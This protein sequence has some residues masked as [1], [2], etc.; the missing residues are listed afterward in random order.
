MGT[1]GGGARRDA[2][3]RVH[4]SAA[5]A[6]RIAVAA[7][8]LAGPRPGGTPHLGHARRVV[9]RLGVVQIDAVNVLVRAHRM[10]LYS[11][12][13][14]HPRDLLDRLVAGGHLVETWAH[15]ASLVPAAHYPLLWWRRRRPHPWRTLTALARD[16]PDLL[17]AVHAAVAERGPLTAGEL[18]RAGR[19]S[20]WWGWGPA[21]QALEVLLWQG[22]VAVRR[23][24]D[25][26][27]EYGLP[28]RLLPAAALAPPPPD[29]EARRELVRVAARAL[30]VATLADL[31]DHHR[32]STRDLAPVVA[33]MAEEGTLL[34]VRVEGWREDAYLD[35][36]ARI[37]RRTGA[38]ALVS[39][40]DPVMWG[41]ARA[42]RL[43][44]FRY[45]LEI[46]TPAHRRVHG[47]YVLPFLLGD[48]PVARVD[49]RADRRGGSLQVR[50]AHA[51]DAAPPGAA[52][53][54]AAELRTLARWLG[55]HRV[56]T[57]DRGDLAPALRAA[58]E[59]VGTDGPG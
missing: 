22:R 41:R 37:P 49:L 53:R 33:G 38:A 9:D 3:S 18:E 32:Q 11:R 23:R 28:E 25:F 20:P 48:R 34:P 44:G 15:E 39:P 43:W 47:Y 35:P 46:Y 21:K 40:F 26:T 24:P 6:R 12:L 57:D 30:G 14:P 51:E 55:L 27:R 45:R 50:A 16:R 13:G 2:P 8:G 59:V 1:G 31:A 5:E 10:P 17:D 54:L 52:G 42:E 58:L 36:G 7:A 4:L 29:D 19:A 56:E